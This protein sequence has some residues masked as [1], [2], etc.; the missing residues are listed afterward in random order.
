[1]H[2][3]PQQLVAVR[4][5]DGLFVGN[6]TS[7]QD[8]EFLFMNKVTHIVNCAGSET[9]NLYQQ[10][11]IHY[12][13]FHWRDL[14]NTILFDAE[15]RNVRQIFEFIEKGLE[16]GECVLVHSVLGVSRS[17]AVV[18]A[19]LMHKYG[20][21]LDNTVA[22][23]RTAHPDMDVKPYFLRQLGL[24]ARRLELEHDIFHPELD[25]S[26][27]ALDNEQWMLRNT[28]TNSLGFDHLRNNDIRNAV[29]SHEDRARA[30]PPP[31]SR[32]R[33]TFSDTGQGTAVS[34]AV[35]KP[36][37]A[38]KQISENPEKLQLLP[39]TRGILAKAPSVL[40]HA[41]QSPDG[42]QC[43]KDVW[44]LKSQ[45]PNTHHAAAAAL[46]PAAAAQLHQTQP[47]RGAEN[48]QPQPP[49]MTVR[50]IDG[51]PG[52]AATAGG[53]ANAGAGG[54]NYSAFQSRFN[55][56]AG[57]AGPPVAVAGPPAAT[58]Q[59]QPPPPQVQQQPPQQLRAGGYSSFTS[60]LQPQQAGGS[61]MQRPAADPLSSR[62]SS[63]LALHPQQQQAPPPQA[64]TQQQPAY[65]PVA[66]SALHGMQNGTGVAG[67]TPAWANVGS[68]YVN[69]SLLR[70]EE[71]PGDRR[72]VYQPLTQ[73]KQPAK[74]LSRR[75][76]GDVELQGR[77]RASPSL[78]DA[79][80]DVA[81]PAPTPAA[82]AAAAAASEQRQPPQR[83]QQPRPTRQ[84]LANAGN[85]GGLRG[86][87]LT[88]QFAMQGARKG[89]PLPQ[90][91]DV[92][93]QVCFLLGEEGGG[94]GRK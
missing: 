30:N 36:I 53:G 22:F 29:L 65:S 55:Q 35:T 91:Q 94:G 88:S 1:M 4:I 8:D 80:D 33:I 56:T 63:P 54:V 37:I 18:A 51:P 61:P 77:G 23:M 38:G 86:R 82:A 68:S 81:Q 48:A 20:W 49:T 42:L 45:N 46:K 70:Q 90:R 71:R 12:L 32:R 76:A 59:H 13:S 83:E 15:G 58:H 27:F 24:L 79:Q 40:K 5:K 78:R 60:M 43:T 26:R 19:Y 50:R 67:G 9:P 66:G 41:L 57:A 64:Q 44:P 89:S 10:A 72:D 11:N 3:M 21:S 17:C 93:N 39:A 6:Q 16:K 62:T 69:P 34:S 74:E 85:G 75:D 25:V 52:G 47:Y 2:A 31:P 14:P 87:Q 84:G 73:T 28:Y 92:K 7:S